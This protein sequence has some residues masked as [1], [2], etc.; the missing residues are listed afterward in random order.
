MVNVQKSMPRLYVVN[1]FK[2]KAD[3][4]PCFHPLSNIG[5]FEILI[6]TSGAAAA[7]ATSS[8]ASETTAI[9]SAETAP[10]T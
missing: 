1:G 7:K 3:G 5:L 6:I 8:K 2:Q 4:R 9:A 10:V